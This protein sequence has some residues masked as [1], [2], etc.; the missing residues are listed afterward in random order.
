MLVG[1]NKDKKKTLIIVTHDAHIAE[2]ADQVIV[3]K[4]GR[5]VRNHQIHKEIYTA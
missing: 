1:L 5:M 2:M 4:D 3:I